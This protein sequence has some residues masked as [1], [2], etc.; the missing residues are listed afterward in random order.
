MSIEMWTIEQN[1]ILRKTLDLALK[2]LLR[3]Q[4]KVYPLN[5]DKV[6]IDEA[7]NEIQKKTD[8]N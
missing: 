2:T 5:P 3:V 1:V 6:W 7:I 8:C 4:S